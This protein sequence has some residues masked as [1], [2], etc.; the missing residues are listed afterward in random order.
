MPVT[1]S[2]GSPEVLE[3]EDGRYLRWRTSIAAFGTT[4]LVRFPCDDKVATLTLLELVDPAAPTV[5]TFTPELGVADNF[6]VGGV[7]GRVASSSADA[8][9]RSQSPVALDLAD[10]ALF[11]RPVPSS[12]PITLAVVC[13]IREG[14]R[15]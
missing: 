7:D 1:H 4:D 5:T 13:V 2:A 11:V 15:V 3:T 6:T 12:G 8:P 9:S 10:G 14:H